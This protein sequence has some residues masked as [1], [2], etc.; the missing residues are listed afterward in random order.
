MQ[1]VFVPVVRIPVVV[2]VVAVNDDVPAVRSRETRAV[3]RTSSGHLVVSERDV[4]METRR[5][6]GEKLH[7]GRSIIEPQVLDNQVLPAD[8][9]V[10]VLKRC[11]DT[12]IPTA[13]KHR[14]RSGS[15][16]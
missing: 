16:P 3:F 4:M 5:V 15:R 12:R 2:N 11:R 13:D 8:P 1:V 7:A 9:N 10:R 6:L 14:V